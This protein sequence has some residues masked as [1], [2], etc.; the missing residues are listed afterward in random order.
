MT[1][2]IN[3]DVRNRLFFIIL[4]KVKNRE[5]A[6]DITQESISILLEAIH[7]NKI[8]DLDKINSFLIGTSYNLIKQYF[9]TKAKGALYSSEKDCHALTESKTTENLLFSND[10][11]NAV[12]KALKRMNRR[13]QAALKSYYLLGMSY[14]EI[15]SQLNITLNHLKVILHRARKNFKKHFRRLK[16]SKGIRCNLIFAILTT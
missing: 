6:E 12:R 1:F 2:E 4:K 15:S 8:N 3:T 11:K 10:I 7:A 5:S 16:E 13:E 14:E 9:D